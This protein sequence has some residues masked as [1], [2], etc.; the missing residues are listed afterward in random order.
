LL[1]LAS[2]RAALRFAALVDLGFLRTFEARVAATLV[3]AF[4]FAI[5]LKVPRLVNLG[6][7]RVTPIDIG[8]I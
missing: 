4:L 2:V 7:G 5:S 3:A 8:L 6:L 1:R